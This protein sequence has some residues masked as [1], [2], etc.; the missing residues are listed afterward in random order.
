MRRLALA[1]TVAMSATSASANPILD[2]L[3][4][5]I[6]EG[7]GAPAMDW[8]G[9]YAGAHVGTGTADMNFLHA[10]DDIVGQMLHGLTMESAGGISRWPL[11]G[12]MSNKGNG[13]GGFVG[14]NAQWGQAVLGVEIN[15]LKGEFGGSDSGSMGRRFTVGNLEYNVRATSAASIQIHDMGSIRGRAGYAV[16]N[17]LPYAFGGVSLG[18]ADIYRAASVSGS[19]RDVVT[20]PPPASIPFNYSQADVQNGHFIYGYAAGLGLDWALFG[21]AFL[22]AEWEYLKFTAPIDTSVNTVR[23]GAGMRF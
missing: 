11:M 4:G 22:R 15:Y 20:L 7:V 12:K 5:P 14:Y 10:T 16:G 6:L 23:V 9:Y 21:N 2:V 18:L 1:L 19:E 17:F 13:W 8:T 3:R